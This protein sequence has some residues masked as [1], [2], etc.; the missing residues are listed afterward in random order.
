MSLCHLSLFMSVK[1]LREDL[2]EDD[3]EARTLN[4]TII[5]RPTTTI[6]YTK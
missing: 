4:T 3:A 5:K 2:R 6:I 1:T